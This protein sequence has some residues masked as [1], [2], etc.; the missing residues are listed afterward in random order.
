ML[1]R[2]SDQPS[3]ALAARSST[4]RDGLDRVS[5]VA[6]EDGGHAVNDGGALNRSSTSPREQWDHPPAG[7][8]RH[9]R[10]HSEGTGV[11]T[12]STKRTTSER[13]EELVMLQRIRKF[14]PLIPD[15]PT[16]YFNIGHWLTTAAGGNTRYNEPDT[17]LDE[18]ALV[19]A[20]LAYQLH[21]RALCEAICE[22]QRNITTSIKSLHEYTTRSEQLTNYQFRTTQ[23]TEAMFSKEGKC[24]ANAYLLAMASLESQVLKTRE[25]VH[26][27][28]QTLVK[29]NDI[30][31]SQHELALG[32]KTM[33]GRYPVLARAYK[34]TVSTKHPGGVNVEKKRLSIQHRRWD[35]SSVLLTVN[36]VLAEGIH[37]NGSNAEINRPLSP[38]PSGE[39]SIVSSGPSVSTAR[40]RQFVHQESGPSHLPRDIVAAA[41]TASSSSLPGVLESN[42]VLPLRSPS[43]WARSMTRRPIDQTSNNNNNNDH[44]PVATAASSSYDLRRQDSVLSD[45]SIDFDTMLQMGCR[46]TLPDTPTPTPKRSA[47]LLGQPGRRSPPVP[48]PPAATI[49]ASSKQ[50]DHHH[51]QQQQQQH[52]TRLTRSLNGPPSPQGSGSHRSST[53]DRPVPY[54]IAHERNSLKRQRARLPQPTDPMD[55]EAMTRQ[56][57]PSM[58]QD[59]PSP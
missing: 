2:Q 32:S 17:A 47:P 29:L 38:Q 42:W 43:F 59:T 18:Q 20:F 33:Q 41:A 44:T 13:E 23:S 35:R 10:A 28:M 37:G 26:D 40:L 55:E 31:G 9:E 24:I 45:A 5:E 57:L 34:Q 25:L 27:I 21:Q 53:R 1:R 30:M 6:N 14:S 19:G 46:R 48:S 52:A 22:R 4:A 49:L 58:V 15:Q 3:L 50:S 56:G 11:V 51:Q 36:P 16:T 8:I 12:I 39:I 54:D 7:F